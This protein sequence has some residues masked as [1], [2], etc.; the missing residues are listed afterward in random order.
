MSGI[1]PP[2]TEPGSPNVLQPFWSTPGSGQGSHHA[3]PGGLAAHER[4]QV[5][6]TEHED[7]RV[8]RVGGLDRKRSESFRRTSDWQQSILG[9]LPDIPKRFRQ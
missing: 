3:Y 2:G 1:F 9:N 4:L 7:E 6:G 8:R 5:F